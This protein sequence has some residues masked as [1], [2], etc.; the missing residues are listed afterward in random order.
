ME[1]APASPEGAETV[2]AGLE[3]SELGFTAAVELSPK[4]T[5]C[6][7]NSAS[8]E[9]PRTPASAKAVA[10]LG[11]R[12]PASNCEIAPAVSVTAAASWL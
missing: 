4:K 8:T 7:P 3:P 6:G 2:A 11:I 1:A 5:P 12:S 10:K 9:E